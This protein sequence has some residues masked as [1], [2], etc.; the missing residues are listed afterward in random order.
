MRDPAREAQGKRRTASD[1]ERMPGS[2]CTQQDSDANRLFTL[3]L[4]S[5]RY[6]SRFCAQVPLARVSLG[7]NERD[8]E[9]IP[10]ES[11]QK[12]LRAE[13]R[14]RARP[15]AKSIKSVTL[16]QDH[17]SNRNVLR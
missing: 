4:E 11:P 6:R 2:T 3:L 16:A 15:A 1:S 12:I 10:S 8:K 7:A 17:R 13:T 14:S 9:L 5:A